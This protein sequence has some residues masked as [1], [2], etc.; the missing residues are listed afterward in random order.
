MS[1][2]DLAKTVCVVVGVGSALWCGIVVAPVPL[3]PME[4]RDRR[5]ST[6]C[7][8]LCV[9][10]W[11]MVRR[12]RLP[13]GDMVFDSGTTHSHGTGRHRRDRRSCGCVRRSSIR[14]G[15]QSQ[16]GRRMECAGRE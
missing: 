14:R 9:S 5:V 7:E 11:P 4:Y 6:S 8:A 1:V 13:P 12:Q 3:H 15:A 2:L 10:P 16:R